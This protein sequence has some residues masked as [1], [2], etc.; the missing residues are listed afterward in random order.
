LHRIFDF[1]GDYELLC[2]RLSPAITVSEARESVALLLRLKFLKRDGKGPFHQTDRVISVK[3]NAAD[4][5]VIEKF[6]TEMLKMALR[7]YDDIPRNDR[8]SASTTFS[9][10][11]ATFNLFKMKTRE[12]RK[13][14]LEIARLDDEP[15]RAYQFTFN[16]FPLSKRLP[17]ESEK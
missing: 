1:R 8:M 2:A 12:F 4:A 16:L 11:E 3:P 14:L 13:E 6:Q 7:S 9:I 10:S 17:D 15:S 5:F